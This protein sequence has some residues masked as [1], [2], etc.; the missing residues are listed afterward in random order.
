VVRLSASLLVALACLVLPACKR[1]ADA[2]KTVEPPPK[3]G[4]K[5]SAQAKGE[6]TRV[7]QAASSCRQQ[8]QEA[9][10]EHAANTKRVNEAKVLDMK[11]VT[12]REQ[13]EAKRETVRKFLASNEA[14]KSLLMN[15]EAI[16]KE[17]LAKL[18]VPQAGIKSAVRGFQ[19]SIPG[20]AVAIRMRGTDQRI[21]DSVLGALDFLD[22]TWGQWNYN[23]EYEQVQFSP[24]GALK[25]YTEFMEAIEAASREQNELQE[26]LKAEGS[27]GP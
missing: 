22:E 19:S 3:A 12:Q 23:K 26:Q 18:Q 8:I 16:F 5:S 15:E 27:T 6:E 7:Q 20:K 24:P 2:A 9:A 14:L 10:R 1:A 17:E 11:E 13:V 21:G 4:Q 25:K